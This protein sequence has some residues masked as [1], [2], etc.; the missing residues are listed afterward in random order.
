MEEICNCGE[1]TTCKMGDAMCTG[2]N[3][4]CPASEAPAGE[5]T[6]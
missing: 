2:C 3:K 1:H 6:M 4:K 5:A